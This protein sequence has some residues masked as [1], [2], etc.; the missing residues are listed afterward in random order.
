LASFLAGG[1]DLLNFFAAG[2]DM[3]FAGLDFLDAGAVVSKSESEAKELDLRLSGRFVAGVVVLELSFGGLV[4]QLW[5]VLGFAM[6]SGE[7]NC[8]KEENV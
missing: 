6:V 4:S 7:R 5:R 8:C 1:V 3:D 2:F